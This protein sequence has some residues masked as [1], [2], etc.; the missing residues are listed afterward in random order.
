MSQERSAAD[1]ATAAR[2]FERTI[3]AGGFS[4]AGIGM[5]V[6][7]GGA[8][9]A[10]RHVLH[11]QCPALAHGRACRTTNCLTGIQNARRAPSSVREEKKIVTAPIGVF[12]CWVP[13]VR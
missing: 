11:W 2:A 4:R 5:G 7:I 13:D 8:F 1:A 6:S 12:R 9:D 3:A 10:H